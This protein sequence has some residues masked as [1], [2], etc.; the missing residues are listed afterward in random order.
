M[1]GL[2]GNEPGLIGY[3][4]FADGTG[5]DLSG[6]GHDAA[7]VGNATIVSVNN[8]AGMGRQYLQLMNRFSGVGPYTIEAVPPGTNCTLSAFIDLTGTGKL[9]P[10]DPSGQFAG[11]PF[12]LTADKTGANIILSSPVTTL[13]LTRSANQIQLTWLAGSLQSAPALTG[14]WSVVTGATSPY[15]VTPAGRAGFYRLAE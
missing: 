1:P 7:L 10:G 5:K 12:S 9:A 4:D 15:T 6:N 11:N 13:T 8:P 3:W 14:P 2:Q